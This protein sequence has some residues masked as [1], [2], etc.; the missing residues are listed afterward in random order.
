MIDAKDNIVEDLPIYGHQFGRQDQD[1]TSALP[2]F[3]TQDNCAQSCSLDLIY[4]A[5]YAFE[6]EV[7]NFVL[8]NYKLFELLWN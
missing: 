2:Y 6:F 8:H 1:D 7:S 3:I 5:P 4:Q